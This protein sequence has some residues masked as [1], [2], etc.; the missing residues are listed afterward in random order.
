MTYDDEREAQVVAIHK[1]AGEVLA[2]LGLSDD[3]LY[4]IANQAISDH[5]QHNDTTTQTIAPDKLCQLAWIM[6]KVDPLRFGV[7]YEHAAMT[8]TAKPIGV[9]IAD[10]QGHGD[11]APTWW[12]VYAEDCWSPPIVLVYA[13]ASCAIDVAVDSDW[14]YLFT[15]DEKE[16]A[17]FIADEKTSHARCYREA[18]H[19]MKHPGVQGQV[20]DW[21]RSRWFEALKIGPELSDEAA[22]ERL[23]GSGQVCYSDG[24]T[25]YHGE[26]I[27][28]LEFT[29][30]EYKID[31]LHAFPTASTPA[32]LLEL[33]GGCAEQDKSDETY[34]EECLWCLVQY[35]SQYP[36]GN[37]I[38]DGISF[39]FTYDAGKPFGIAISAVC[40]KCRAKVGPDLL[41]FPV[42][43]EQCTHAIDKIVA[44]AQKIEERE[45]ANASTPAQ[46]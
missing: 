23:Q 25:V 32:E 40:P 11:N 44:S 35:M 36:I 24:G 15:L 41:I 21:Q 4:D 31:W 27:N 28:M 13:P 26:N 42:T 6:G 22:M 19:E 3:D 34:E 18:E 12:M 20:P 17:E 33:L 30:R 5:L 16:V 1:Q 38:R 8:G 45:A 39:E 10:D 14:G 29:K 43:R 37:C 2:A 46:A 7:Q 9:V